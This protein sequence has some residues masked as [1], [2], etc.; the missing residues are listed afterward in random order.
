MTPDVQ[1]GGQLRDDLVGLGC[2][3][4]I[5][6]NGDSFDAVLL[7]CRDASFRN[8]FKYTKGEQ[9][10]IAIM[11]T[12]VEFSTESLS[13]FEDIVFIPFK[14]EEMLARINLA[15]FRINKSIVDNIYELEG[16]RINF[17]NY[18]VSVDGKQL[19]LTYKEYELL[20]HLITAPGRVFTRSQLLK[21]VWGYDYIEGARTV[22]VHIRRLRSKLGSKYATLIETVRHVGYRFKRV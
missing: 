21:N 14:K 1:F 18:E 11:S 17:T 13:E 2:Y 5:D 20:R 6:K 10:V 15:L 12:P 7:D 8:G 16:F 3:A 22:D 9:A 4:V 19:D